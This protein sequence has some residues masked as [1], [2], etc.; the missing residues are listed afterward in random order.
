MA[1]ISIVIQIQGIFVPVELMFKKFSYLLF[2]SENSSETSALLYNSERRAEI[3]LRVL[4]CTLLDGWSCGLETGSRDPRSRER[5]CFLCGLPYWKVWK[6]RFSF[7]SSVWRL[8][9]REMYIRYHRIQ[10]YYYSWSWCRSE[11]RNQDNSSCSSL[12]WNSEPWET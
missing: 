1:I 12:L 11:P 3:S 9:G 7:G 2:F 10:S 4:H 6:L 5:N 8:L